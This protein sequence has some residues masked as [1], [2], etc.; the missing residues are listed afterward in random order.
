MIKFA[1]YGRVSTEDQ[2]DPESSRSWQ[3]TRSRAL[4]ES[5]DGVIVTEFFD[6]DKSRS[7]PWQRRPQATALLAELRNPSREL[8]RGGDRRAAPRLLRQPVRSHVPAVRALRRTAVGAR[9]RR[10]DRPRERGPRPGDV[11]VRRDEQGRAE[12]DQDPRPQPPW[13][14]RP[15]IEGRFL[16]GRPPYGYLLADAGPHPNPAKAADGKRLHRA[17]PRPGDRPGGAA[18][19]RRV[20]RRARLLRHRRGPDPRRHPQPVRPRPRA[21]PPP[22]R[23][24]VE[25]VRCPRDPR[26]PPLHRPSGLE[27]AAQGRGAH[28]R[29]GRRTRPHDQAAAGTNPVQWVWSRNIVQPPIIDTGGLRS[30]AGHA[31]RARDQARRAQAAPHAAPVRAA[32]LRLVRAV[33]AGRMQ[34]HW[35]N[36]HPV[37]PVPVPRRVRAGQPR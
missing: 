18:D 17:R 29:R 23:H 21:E 37:L 26:Q 28:R 2:Q 24:R 13:P 15:E 34:G 1:F 33:R 32:R 30:G 6:V 9:G 35:V 12:P 3:L 19:L 10:S 16:G 27:Q 8:R 11:G 25:Q 5:R 20:H 4:I 22:L 31:Q 36:G 7:I 14:H